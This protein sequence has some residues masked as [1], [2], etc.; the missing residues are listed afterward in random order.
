MEESKTSIHLTIRKKLVR[1]VKKLDFVSMIRVE[2]GGLWNKRVPFYTSVPNIILSVFL[3]V[4][5]LVYAASQISNYGSKLNIQVD[6]KDVEH[7]ITIN[8]SAMF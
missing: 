3:T 1:L 4:F 5:L 2:H 6:Y 7:F 8:T